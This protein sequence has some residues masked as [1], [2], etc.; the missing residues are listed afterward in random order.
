M[1]DTTIFDQRYGVII[2]GGG[3]AGAVLAS[4][5]SEDPSRSVLLLEAGPDYPTGDFPPDLLAGSKASVE[6]F[7]TWGYA[8]A[9]DT[10]GHSI[11]VWAGRVI[12]GGSAI[13]G[14]ISR[15]ARP[16]DFA[17]WTSRGLPEWSWDQVLDTSRALENTPDGD[18]RFHGRSGAWPVRQGRL[19]DLTKSV[20]TYVEAAIA[21]GYPEITD[22]NDPYH[23]GGAGAEA[24]NIVDGIRQN[25]AMTYLDAGVR[26]RPNLTILADVLADRVRIDNGRATAVRLASGREVVGGEIVLSAGTF[27]S[28]GLLLRSGIGPSE[29]LEALGIDVVADLP[30]GLNLQDHPMFVL[31]FPLKPDAEVTSFAGSGIVWVA[32]P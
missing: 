32:S 23:C 11:A 19:H 18:E 17:R 28:A 4:R 25:T 1:T 9:P 10:N 21:A 24:T 22:F 8:S 29:H 14:A 2:I 13:N 20:R 12:G 3:S 30:V 26:S 6:P 7:R 16:S 5:I 27:G 15:R 31:G